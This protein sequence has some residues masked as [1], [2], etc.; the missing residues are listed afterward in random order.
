M[1]WGGNIRELENFIYR[2]AVIS[3]SDILYPPIESDSEGV[4]TGQIHGLR[5]AEF[6]GASGR[7][8][9]MKKELIIKTLKETKGNRTRAAELL[10]INVR[11]IRN[12]IKEYD[13]KDEDL[14]E[15]V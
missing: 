13:I 1:N 9:D 15:I 10:G 6:V 2:T 5:S 11:T 8:K 4:E 3:K 7:M 14:K 12:K